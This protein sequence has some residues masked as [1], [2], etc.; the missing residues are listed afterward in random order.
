MENYFFVTSGIAVISAVDQGK[1]LIATL[2][3]LCVINLTVV[4]LIVVVLKGMPAFDG[5][6]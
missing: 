6:E 2:L 5:K 4:V 3:L 1:W